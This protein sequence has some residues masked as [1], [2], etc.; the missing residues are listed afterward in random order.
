MQRPRADDVSVAAGQC[1]REGAV[2]GQHCV[3]F[4]NCLVKRTRGEDGVGG[5]GR[6]GEGDVGRSGGVEEDGAV[7]G[8]LDHLLGSGAPVPAEAERLVE[9]GPVVVKPVAD[10]SSVDVRLVRSVDE[11][12]AAGN[13]AELL[14][15][16]FLAGREFTV[17]VLGELVLPVVEIELATEIFDYASKYQPGAV[18]EI[19]PADVTP[20]FAARLQELARTA[21][22]VLGFGP[23]AYSRT[24]FRCDADGTPYCLEINALPGLSP[25]SLIPRAA[26]GHGWTYADLADHILHLG[27]TDHA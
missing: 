9:A 24:D 17:G 5:G 4:G 21:H 11:L 8:E 2:A 6:E 26:A 12:V 13:A 3:A 1:V 20:A 23:A 15:E 14:V 27:T 7:H 16:P 22:D 19:C 18:R 10:G 25:A